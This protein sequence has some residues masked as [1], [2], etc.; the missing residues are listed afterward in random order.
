M[1]NIKL[2]S[3]WENDVKI[4]KYSARKGKTNKAV[5]VAVAD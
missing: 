4:W 3:A 2:T 1:S 5:Q